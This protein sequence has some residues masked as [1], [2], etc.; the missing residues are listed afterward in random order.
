MK[1]PTSLQFYPGTSNV[2]LPVKN[3]TFLP[4]EYQQQTRLTYYASLFPSV[5]INSSFYR[6]PLSRTVKKWASEVPDHFRFTFK[7]LKEVTHSV[8]QAFNQRGIPEFLERIAGA[9]VKKGCLLV[10]LPPSFYININQLRILLDHFAVSDSEHSWPVAIEFRHPSWYA[11]KVY[12]LLLAHN[13]A[14]VLQD[15]PK[16]A[17]PMELTSDNLV[18]L[19]FHGPEGGYRGSYTDDFLFEYAGYIQEWLAE[20]RTVYSYFNNTAGSAVQNLIT[21]NDFVAVK[22]EKTGSH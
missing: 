10:Q 20:G 15:M 2:V 13:V 4:E 5:E 22:Q 7:L 19:R 8:K 6:M 16:S 18:Y 3:K 17:T 11:D 1:K 21:L 14:M 9:G 12:E